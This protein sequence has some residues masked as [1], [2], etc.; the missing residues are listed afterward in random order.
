MAVKRYGY[1][2]MEVANY[3]N[4]HYSAISRLIKMI[5]KVKGKDLTP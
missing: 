1:R 2:Q 4:L 3:L 5:G